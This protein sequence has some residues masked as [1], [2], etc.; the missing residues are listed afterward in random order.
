MLPRCQD[1]ALCDS[2]TAITSTIKTACHHR[3]GV[4]SGRTATTETGGDVHYTVQDTVHNGV[5]MA[6]Y[7]LSVSTHP[8]GSRSNSY[9]DT[10]PRQPFCAFS[11]GL[12]SN[13][14]LLTSALGGRFGG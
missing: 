2:V 11:A 5:Q 3:W 4:D 6:R 9:G 14:L 12:Q 1:T 7:V 10:R 13:C 8:R